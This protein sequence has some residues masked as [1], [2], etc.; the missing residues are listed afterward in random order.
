[1]RDL[2]TAV[3]F[4]QGL[5]DVINLEIDGTR[6][7]PNTQ[8]QKRIAVELDDL[9]CRL[10]YQASGIVA[11]PLAL[12]QSSTG[13][14]WVEPFYASGGGRAVVVKFGDFH[15]IQEEYTNFKQYNNLDREGKKEHLGSHIKHT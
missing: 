6:V 3:D 9:L 11:R 12:G 10:F 8:L 4:V 7:Q 2:A 14:L 5:D 13:V 15:K 1:M